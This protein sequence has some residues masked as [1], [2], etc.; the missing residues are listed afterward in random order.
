MIRI[1]MSPT[2]QVPS[3]TLSRWSLRLSQQCRCYHSHFTEVSIHT[4]LIP[5]SMLS[6]SC[7][8]AASQISKV[9]KWPEYFGLINRFWWGDYQI[10]VC[11]EQ[12]SQKENHSENS[13][14]RHGSSLMFLLELDFPGP[15]NWLRIPCHISPFWIKKK[16]K[17][18]NTIF[19]S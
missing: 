10:C 9:P 16:N 4:H 17:Q 12:V 11:T 15:I 3:Q 1:W 5:K 13:E 18:K 8:Q 2:H 19:K 14:Y 7:P 6:S